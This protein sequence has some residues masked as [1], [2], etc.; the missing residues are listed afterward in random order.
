MFNFALH[1]KGGADDADRTAAVMLNFEVKAE[2]DSS[3]GHLIRI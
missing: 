2:G 3:D 1:A